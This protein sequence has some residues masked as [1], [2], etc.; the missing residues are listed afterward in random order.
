MKLVGLDVGPPRLPALPLSMENVK[1]LEKDLRDIGFFD[2]AWPV[3]APP[4]Y[5]LTPID[6]W[7]VAI[8]MGF[9]FN[10]RMCGVSCVVCK[11][12][13]CKFEQQKQEKQIF[14]VFVQV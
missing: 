8:Y 5:V 6:L 1:S 12:H 7:R 13:T 10:N 3:V 4:S 2:W 14:F 9:F 11:T